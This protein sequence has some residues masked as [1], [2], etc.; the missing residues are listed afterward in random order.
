MHAVIVDGDVSY[1]P[2]SGK[3][4]RTLHLMLRLAERHQVTYIA[5]CEA[6]G[7]ESRQA[8]EFLGD[9]HIEPI[10]V[11]QPLPSKKGLRFYGRL[12]ANLASA[13]PYSVTSHQGANMRAAV[14]D[15]AAGHDV[16][17]WQFEWSAYLPTLS[18][19]TPGSR[20]LIAHNVDTLIWQRYYETARGFAKRLFLKQQWRRFERFERWAFGQ[21]DGVVAV[22][23]E[24]AALVRDHFGQPNVD[25]VENGIDRAYF[26][27]VSGRRDPRRILFLGAL[28]WRPN[29]D[30]VHLLLDTI[31][32]QVLAQE[33][34]ARLV[35]VGRNPAEALVRRVAALPQVELHANVPDVRPFLAESGVMTVPLRIGGGSRL[36]I[37]EALASGLPVVS[38]RIGAE[39][40]CLRPGE[41]YTLD[42]PDMA[43]ALVQAL[44]QPEAAQ[45]MARKGRELVLETYD[46]DTLAN[47]LETIWERMT[48]DHRTPDGLAVFRGS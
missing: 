6:L 46:W 30:A 11:D 4:L 13:W 33:P 47:K 5:R 1:P 36:K 18:R 39:G 31:F 16:D 20:L 17:L 2:T 35:L 10:L 14:H 23:P 8:K 7:G 45:K 24:D 15:Y 37:L 29:Q 3:R 40:L 21:A 12:A 26:E 44:R 34:Q 48:Y 25:V 42:E 28:D 27:G 22:S 32:P 43:A 19:D 41:H 9:H 38:S